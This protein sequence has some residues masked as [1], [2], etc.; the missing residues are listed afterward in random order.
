MTR[1][2]APRWSGPPVIYGPGEVYFN[3]GRKENI[4]RLCR[5]FMASVRPDDEPVD[6]D[7]FTHWDSSL[8]PAE[9]A[10]GEALLE[11]FY[12]SANAGWVQ[13]P[14]MV[15]DEDELAGGEA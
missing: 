10:V 14:S 8:T 12:E 3:L 11:L 5:C 4:A 9:K 6:L 7:I 15:E 13:P 2:P 1:Y